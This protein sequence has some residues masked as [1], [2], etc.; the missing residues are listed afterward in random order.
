M[1]HYT[2]WSARERRNEARTSTKPSRRDLG[3]VHLT[4]R[5]ARGTR[6]AMSAALAADGKQV[7]T[8]PPNRQLAAAHEDRFALD[9]V[10]P[11]VLLAAAVV[12]QARMDQAHRCSSNCKKSPNRGSVSLSVAPLSHMIG[13]DLVCNAA[14]KDSLPD[15]FPTAY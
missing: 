14:R 13:R 4:A 11:F 5:P 15:G 12:H 3:A 7:E 9:E 1:A 2:L 10:S 6:S 8:K